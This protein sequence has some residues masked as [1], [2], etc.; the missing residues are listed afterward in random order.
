MN[1]HEILTLVND[2][3][4][5]AGVTTLAVLVVS[6]LVVRKFRN[7]NK[8]TGKKCDRDSLSV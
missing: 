3:P 8:C 6:A 1:L 7:R 2:N 5:F 4:V